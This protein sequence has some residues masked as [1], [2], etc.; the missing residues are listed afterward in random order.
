MHSGAIG[1]VVAVQ[2]TYIRNAPGGGWNGGPWW[3]IDPAAGPDATSDEHIN[4]K[5]WLG[6]APEM[7]WTPGHFFR[8]RKYWDYSGGIATDL[9]FHVVAPFHLAIANTNTSPTCVSGMGGLWV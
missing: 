9:H 2:D 7:P 4:W 8:F 3:S 6:S 1:Q 5:H